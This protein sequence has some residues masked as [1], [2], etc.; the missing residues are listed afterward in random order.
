M[1]DLKNVLVEF[2][3]AMEAIGLERDEEEHADAVVRGRRRNAGLDE[4]FF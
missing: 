1:E 3:E 4:L 2:E